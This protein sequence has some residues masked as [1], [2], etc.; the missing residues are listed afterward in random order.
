MRCETSSRTWPP[1]ANQI[2]VLKLVLALDG[3]WGRRGGGGGSVDGWVVYRSWSN[4]SLP[5]ANAA[6]SPE[7][8]F[9]SHAAHSGPCR[10]PWHRGLSNTVGFLSEPY[11]RR[12][13]EGKASTLTIYTVGG[14]STRRRR[15]VKGREGRDPGRRAWLA[16][17]E[18]VTHTETLRKK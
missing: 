7:A 17:Q 18:V 12:E 6:D 1:V 2:L 15:E 13:E 14:G 16:G 8:A 10:P 3:L 11:G 4:R 9:I 5:S